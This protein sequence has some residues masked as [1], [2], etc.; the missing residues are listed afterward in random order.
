MYVCLSVY[1]DVFQ[2]VFLLTDVSTYLFCIY[3]YMYR[4]LHIHICIHIYMYMCI[5]IYTYMYIYI[6]VCVS[7]SLFYVTVGI[8]SM[9]SGQ[10]APCLGTWAWVVLRRLGG[11]LAYRSLCF[12]KSQ[13]AIRYVVI[14]SRHYTGALKLDS[15]YRATKLCGRRFGHSSFCYQYITCNTFSIP[16]AATITTSPVTVTVSSIMFVVRCAFALKLMVLHRF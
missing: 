3:V 1:T 6:Y 5:Y 4:S 9:T 11:V 12:Q 15:Y 13:D 10:Y 16:I 7:L 2:I 8:L 14:L